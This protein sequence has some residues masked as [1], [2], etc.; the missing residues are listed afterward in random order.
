MASLIKRDTRPLAIAPTYNITVR[1][2]AMYNREGVL[3]AIQTVYRE[4]LKFAERM[5]EIKSVLDVFD[6]KK[7]VD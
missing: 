2:V 3:C 6:N 4:H 5:S 1:H 7:H